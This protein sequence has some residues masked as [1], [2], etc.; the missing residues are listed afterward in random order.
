MASHRPIPVGV[1]S[2]A[3]SEEAEF[4]ELVMGAMN[5]MF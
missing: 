5:P 3:L 4:T 1:H 2:A